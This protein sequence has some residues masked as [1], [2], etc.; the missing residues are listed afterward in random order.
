MR[1]M[2]QITPNKALPGAQINADQIQNQFLIRVIR[3]YP[4]RTLVFLPRASA[5]DDTSS[6]A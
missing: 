4:R 5:P 1:F 2:C 6:V 3:V